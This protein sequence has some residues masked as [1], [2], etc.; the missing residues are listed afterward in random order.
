MK[1]GLVRTCLVL[2][3][4]VLV[5]AHAE[6]LSYTEQNR[7]ILV[8]VWKG[9]LTI[10][11]QCQ[12]ECRGG[13]QVQHREVTLKVTVPTTGKFIFPKKKRSWSTDIE[14]KDGSP[15]MKFGGEMRKFQLSREGVGYR[16]SLNFERKAQ[17]NDRNHALVLTKQ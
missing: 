16:L 13:R 2:A 15:W 10:E 17:G 1:A 4:L 9:E 5:S 3:P 12:G 14:A 8:G 7:D 6:Q 11:R